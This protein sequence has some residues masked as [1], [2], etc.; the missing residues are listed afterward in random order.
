MLQYKYNFQDVTNELRHM[1]LL[2]VAGQVLRSASMHM[3]EQR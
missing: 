2:S 3:L 1:H